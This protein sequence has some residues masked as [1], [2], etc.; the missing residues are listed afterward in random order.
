[1]ALKLP[2]VANNPDIKIGRHAAAIEERRA[3]FS[4]RDFWHAAEFTDMAYERGHV[5]RSHI[6]TDA[7]RVGRGPEKEL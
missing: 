2:H 5:D 6:P 1:M 3:F 7:V 4:P